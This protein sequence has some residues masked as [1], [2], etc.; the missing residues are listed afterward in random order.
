MAQ[1]QLNVTFSGLC[2]F[3]FDRPLKGD[4]K[5]TSAKVLL[6]RLTRARPLS[7]VVNAQPEV[8]DQH[9]PLL[10]FNLADW[11][12]ASTRKADFHYR[13]DDSGR[14][15][16]GVCLLNGEDLMI[17]PDG[18]PA[19]ASPELQL[20]TSAPLN[21]VNPLSGHSLNTL[22]WMVTLDEVFPKNPLNSRIRDVAPAS[23]QPVLGRITLN[24]GYLKTLELTNSPCTIVGAGPTSFNRRVGTS[25]GLEISCQERVEI[26]M[27]AMRNGR[28]TTSSLVLVSRDGAN[29][30]IGIANMEID[31]FIGMDPADGPR[32]QGD[33]E[34]FSNLLTHPIQGQKPFVLE[35]SPG[36]SSSCCGRANCL[37]AGS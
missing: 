19:P 3:D 22:W 36:G 5:P 16:K 23:N 13:P 12:P 8:L 18:K 35:T 33:F 28:T 1:P 14:M 4:P 11:S 31:R 7:R 34:V 10:E 20:S 17:H 26:R 21:P 27:T 6:Q 32:A 2:F 25:F 29:I 9:F 37:V 30:E 24:Q 15:T